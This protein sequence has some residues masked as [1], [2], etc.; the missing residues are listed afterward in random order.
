MA[1]AA[2]EPLWT[3]ERGGCPRPRSIAMLTVMFYEPDATPRTVA[4]DRDR[5][6]IGRFPSSDIVLDDPRVS[7]HHAELRREGD[8]YVATD[9]GSRTGT[10][11]GGAWLRGSTLVSPGD[12]MEIGPFRLAIA[13]SDTWAHDPELGLVTMI[14]ARPHDDAPRLVYADWLEEQGDPRRAEFLRLGVLLKRMP[15]GH[16]DLRRATARLRQLAASLPLGWR[17]VVARPLIERCGPFELV[18]PKSWDA[19]RSTDRDGVRFCAVCE[20]PVHY[21]GTLEEAREHARKGHCV[22]L[23]G[24]IPRTSGDLDVRGEGDDARGNVVT[25]GV[26]LPR[27]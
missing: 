5:L 24:A 25:V 14:R 6:V 17:T 18:C 19:L 10:R 2:E 27:S 11:V 13:S 8:R 23:D 9:L 22:A 20:S 15:G 26:L 16:P 7:P 3:A 21:C 4:F 1:R 12:P